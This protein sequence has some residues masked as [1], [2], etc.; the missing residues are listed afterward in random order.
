MRTWEQTSTGVIGRFTPEQIWFFRT[1]FTDILALLDEVI[2]APGPPDP[3]FALLVWPK[4]DE[5]ARP[6]ARTALASSR[7][8]LLQAVH[9]IPAAGNTVRIESGSTTWAWIWA[10]QDIRAVLVTRLAGNA[11]QRDLDWL[12]RVASELAEAALPFSD[13]GRPIDS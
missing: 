1:N 12:G 7:S 2:A 3:G 5:E 9:T 13:V 6:P 10:L 11:E 8:V 4:L